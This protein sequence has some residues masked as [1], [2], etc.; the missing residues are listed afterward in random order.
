MFPVTPKK[1]LGQHF[2]AD[3]NIARKITGY[4]TC[5]GYDQVIEIGPGMGVLTEFLLEN[6]KINI[7]LIEIDSE[8]A[9]YLKERFPGISDR[10][11]EQDILKYS[12][13]ENYS[14]PVAVIGNFPYNISSQ[15]FFKILESRHLVTEV[16]CMLQKEVAERI[17]SPPGSKVYGILSVLIQA[18]YKTELLFNVGPQVFIPPPRVNSAVIRLTRKHNFN[19]GC[20]ENLFFKLVKAGF[21]QR[22]K[23]LR[24]SLSAFIRDKSAINELLSKRPEQLGVADFVNLANYIESNT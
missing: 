6:D 19:L 11:S 10:I 17:S 22:R 18:F 12:F 14:A 20:N 7:S 13:N 2:L 24:N 16:V 3:R 9:E 8:A 23:M 4:L 15:I 21:N 5:Q 1:S